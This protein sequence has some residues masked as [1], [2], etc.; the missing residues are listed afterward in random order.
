MQHTLVGCKHLDA[1]VSVLLNFSWCLWCV[2][3]VL[4]FSCFL[5]HVNLTIAYAMAASPLCMTG[6]QEHILVT[7][8]HIC[9]LA[10]TALQ[11]R[12]ITQG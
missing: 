3:E 8:H 5:L 4:N 9:S 7:R 10:F 6:L 2:S 1:L 12:N 11:T